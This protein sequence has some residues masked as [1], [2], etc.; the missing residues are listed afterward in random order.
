MRIG[1][2]EG[3][4]GIPF[5]WETRSQVV[6]FL[7]AN[8]PS[9]YI[10]APKADAFL[11]KQWRVP[12]PSD[13]SERLKR[14]AIECK[15][16]GV[17]FGV[18]FSP[19]EIYKNWND[20]SRSSLLKR[21][22]DLALIGVETLAVLL[23]DMNGNFPDLA[24]VQAEMMTWIQDHSQFKSYIFCPTYY[25]DDPVLDRIFGK[26]PNGYLEE[27]G[28]RLNSNVSVFWTGPAICSPE[29]KMEHIVGV[30]E[31]LRRKPT[32]WDNYPVNDGVTMCPFL[33]LKPFLGRPQALKENLADHAINPMNQ[34]I[35]SLIVT[36]T[37]LDSY[38][39]G[40]HYQPERSWQKA[41]LELVGPE[42]TRLLERD[43]KVF[44]E[45]GLEK[46]GEEARRKY[47]SEYEDL[48]PSL[49]QVEVVEWLRGRF[50]VTRELVL[51]Q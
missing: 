48:K 6:K 35:L 1:W 4:Y 29:Y 24:R 42:L 13:Y 22:N 49:A 31:K 39:Q 9:F 44:S 43:L 25:S 40:V 17:E 50:K 51:T 11:R 3:F 2:V 45:I 23:D 7:A 15:A 18:G 10:Y 46:M 34:G 32:L 14:F 20:D 5:S 30:A 28:Q 41:A 26:R 8:G 21:L 38:K 33:H 36:Q 37:L 12:L 16:H 47:L 19:Y 27:L